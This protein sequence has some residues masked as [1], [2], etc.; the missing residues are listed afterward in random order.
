VN[1]VDL[2]GDSLTLAGGDLQE[3]LTAIYNGLEDGT[4]IS[5][6]FNN[7]VLDPSSTSEQVQNTSDVFLQDIYE[8][9]I[10]P[11]MVELSISD[12]NKY[13]QNGKIKNPPFIKPVDTD[14]KDENE[15]YLRNNGLPTGKYILGSLGQTLMPSKSASGKISTN[16]NVQII[17]NGKG[18]LNHRTVGMAHEFGHVILYLRGLPYSHVISGVDAFI[19]DMRAIPMSR[20][21]GYD[22]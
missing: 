22:F 18:S 19:Y 15:D 8:I 1:Y 3:T 2:H 13:K 12:N 9:A 11:T 4:S 16:N 17:I 21:L 10:N 7:G 14:T 20:R 6:K 5:M